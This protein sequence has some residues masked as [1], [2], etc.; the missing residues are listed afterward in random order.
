[1]RSDLSIP[2]TASDSIEK[3]V[4]QSMGFPCALSEG[5]DLLKT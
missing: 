1:M 3:V 4:P 2:S 5:V